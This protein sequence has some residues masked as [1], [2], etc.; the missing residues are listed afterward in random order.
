MPSP[1]TWAALC[2]MTSNSGSNSVRMIIL[3]RLPPTLILFATADIIVFRLTA[4]RADAFPLVRQ[5]FRQNR[6]CANAPII[7]PGLVLRDFSDFDFCLRFADFTLQRHGR[8][9]APRRKMGLFPQPAAAHGP[10]GCGH[11]A[12][13]DLPQHLLLAHLLLD[14]LQRRLCGNGAKQKAC[15]TAISTTAIFCG[16]PCPPSSPV[17][18]CWSFRCGSARPFSNRSLAWPGL[19]RALY[20][21]VAR[22]IPRS[23]SAAPSSFA[24]LLAVTVFLLDFIYALVDPRVKIGDEGSSKA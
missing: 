11:C 1:S 16:P 22:L 5:L 17:L 2:S 15:R 14:L 21:A 10:A 9:S 7:C 18:P 20:Q 8:I 4:H 13:P 6:G 3:E 12:Q 24:Y 23:L 19:G